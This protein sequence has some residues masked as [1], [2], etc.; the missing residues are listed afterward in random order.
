MKHVANPHR[1]HSRVAVVVS[2]KVLK[3]AVRRNLVRRRVY[4][5]V[6]QK[7][8]EFER[9]T[10]VAFIIVSS[11]I[12]TMPYEDLTRLIDQLL[13]TANLYKKDT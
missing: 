4:E 5:V 13:T 3:S 11:E 1:K 7:L 9:P 10:D 2:K 12:M 6:R 8:P